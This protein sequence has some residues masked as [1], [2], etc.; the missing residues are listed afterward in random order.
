MKKIDPYTNPD[1]QAEATL[2]A[3]TNRLEERGKNA[4]FLNMIRDYTS[5]LP[6]DKPLKVLDLGCGTGVVIRE[7]ERVLHKESVLHG[8]DIS[9]NLL[10]QARKLTLQSHIEWDHLNSQALPYDDRC[11]DVVVMHTLLSHVSDPSIV[12]AETFRVLKPKATLIVFDA[13]HASTTYALPEYDDMRRI[14]HLLSSSIATH[15][16]I[17]RQL[18][19]YLKAAG[20]R[21]NSHSSRVLS[22]CGRGDYWLS[23]VQ[24]YAKMFSQLEILESQDAGR[25]VDHMLGSHE[26]GTFFAAGVFYT[27]Y[28]QT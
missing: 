2:Q 5:T 14:D 28:A 23:S 20:F 15:P 27:F 13:D 4:E 17:C 6:H 25:W 22:E 18:P 19:R 26:E 9:E 8:A 24:G 3:M 10:Q 21:I 11:F 16:D 12:L 7:L 1:A